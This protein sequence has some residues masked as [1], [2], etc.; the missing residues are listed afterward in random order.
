MSPPPPP[1]PPPPFPPPSL[2]PWLSKECCCSAS[3]SDVRA[4]TNG[5]ASSSGSHFEWRSPDESVRQPFEADLRSAVS[6]ASQYD[7][8]LSGDALHHLQQQGAD[9][10]YVPLTQ[11]CPQHSLE[12]TQ[13]AAEPH[14]IKDLA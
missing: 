13:E 11:V 12:S 7:L 1:P 9:T 4:T 2:A 5:D 8:C 3:P 14:I 10:S 6:V